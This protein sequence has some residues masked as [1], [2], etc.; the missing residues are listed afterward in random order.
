[1][2]YHTALGLL[3]TAGIAATAVSAQVPDPPAAPAPAAPTPVVI[4]VTDTANLRK[5]ADKAGYTG[6]PHSYYVFNV[7]AK[8]VILGKA[9]GKP[10][11]DTGDWPA[12]VTLA[13]TIGGAVYGGGGNGGNGG[14]VPGTSEGTR[15]GDAIFVRVPMTILVG[16]TGAIKA[17]GGGGGGADGGSQGGSGGGGG[18]PDG[19]PG[20]PGSPSHSSSP[21]LASGDFGHI[22]SPAGG[23]LGGQR[24]NIGGKGGDAGQAGENAGRAG[25]GAGN[26]IRANGNTI[27]FYNYGQLYGV[28]N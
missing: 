7:A 2:I 6:D 25:G 26:A 12:G 24:G 23:G 28:V 20:Q 18:F 1:M 9:G 13:L 16:T 5:L 8:T 10:G 27:R 4:Q 3:V 17:G 21:Y 19:Q 15:G 11:I 14:D 22:G